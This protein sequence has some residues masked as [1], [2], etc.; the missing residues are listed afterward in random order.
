MMWSSESTLA[1]SFLAADELSYFLKLFIL[2][3]GLHKLEPCLEHIFK[4]NR[5][6]THTISDDQAVYGHS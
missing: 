5:V 6:K 3:F 2:A 1:E 4:L